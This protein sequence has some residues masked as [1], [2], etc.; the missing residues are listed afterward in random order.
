MI[1][2]WPALRDFAPGLNLPQV[3]IDYPFG[4][5]TLKAHGKT[6]CWWSPYAD[7]AV[8]YADFD[9]REALIAADSAT[10]FIHPHY[11]KHRLLLLRAGHIAPDWIAARLTARW[12]ALAPKRWL[13]EW[14]AR[15]TIL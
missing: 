11:Q 5:E 1:S 4:N 13:A 8:I 3:A 6:W 2:T 10:F 9:E 14:E 12:R 15:E 7:A